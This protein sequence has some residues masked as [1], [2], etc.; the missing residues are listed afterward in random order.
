[1]CI[2]FVI[3]LQAERV[4]VL[5]QLST[6]QQEMKELNDELQKFQDCDPEVLEAKKQE[7]AVAK[8]AANRW[9]GRH[10]L[11][12]SPVSFILQVRL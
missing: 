7:A 10:I 12:I 2:I 5:E 9:T 8:E 3:L 4:E 1:M 6:K 11:C